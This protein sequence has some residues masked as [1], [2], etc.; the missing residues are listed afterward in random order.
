MVMLEKL[1]ETFL[2]LQ[3]MVYHKMNL[4][5]HMKQ[6]PPEVFSGFATKNRTVLK[7]EKGQASM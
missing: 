4:C 1:L 2:Q 5:F 6:M 3:L 7:I